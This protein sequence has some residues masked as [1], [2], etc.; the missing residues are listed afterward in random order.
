MALAGFVDEIS[1][2]RIE[3]W[4]V[5]SDRPGEAVAVSIM[6]N[7]EHR[8]MCLT[9]DARPDLVTPSGEPVTGKCGFHFAFD[10]PLSPF[11]EQRVDVV[12]TWSAEV[13]PHGS[14]ILPRPR[15]DRGSSTAIV[16]VLLTSTGR[17]GHSPLP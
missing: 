2:S 16:P 10:P 14:A 7:G 11:I 8:G 4:V 17:T 3:G 12:E 9:T 13:L 1:R 6:V 15:V 5:D